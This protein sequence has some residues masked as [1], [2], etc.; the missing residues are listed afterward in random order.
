MRPTTFRLL[1]RSARLAAALLIIA[2]VVHRLGATPFIDGVRRVDARALVAATAITAVTTVV[3]AWRWRLVARGLGLQIPLGSAVSSYYR[4]QFLNSTLPGGVLGDV[5]RGVLHGQQTDNVS[6][7]LRSVGWDR[8]AGQVVQV[9]VASVTLFALA[10]PVRPD[11]TVVGWAAAG[12]AGVVA[13]A[14]YSVRRGGLPWLAR[15]AR[16]A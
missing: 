3:S 14:G 13:L 15:L 2:V 8:A 4:S 7:G 12:A 11:A 16:A 1:W 10:T 9:V 6:R 5:H